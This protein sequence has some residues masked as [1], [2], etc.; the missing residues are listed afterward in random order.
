M[1]MKVAVDAIALTKTWLLFIIVL[2]GLD[3]VIVTTSKLLKK[4]ISD[5]I[6]GN[7]K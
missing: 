7:F 6:V 5:F 1:A 3:N 4:Y 2:N